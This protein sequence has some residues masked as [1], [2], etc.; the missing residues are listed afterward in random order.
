MPRPKVTVTRPKVPSADVLNTAIA[1]VA[2]EAK[3]IETASTRVEVTNVP[4]LRFVVGALAEVKE[5]RAAVQAQLD[6]F[7]KPMQDTIAKLRAF[8][9][10]SLK[11]LKESE[12]LLKVEVLKFLA[13]AES[14]RVRLLEVASYRTD[15]PMVTTALAKAEAYDVPPIKGMSVSERTVGR[16][17][18]PMQVLEWVVDNGRMDLLSFDEKA[19]AKAVKEGAEVPGYEWETKRT[20]SINTKRVKGA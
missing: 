18:D 3:L 8:F 13:F 10:P 16:V 17:V 20:V 5:K 19:L 15:P 4:E 7:V 1:A 12:R 11:S 2:D 6:E 14:E 9:S